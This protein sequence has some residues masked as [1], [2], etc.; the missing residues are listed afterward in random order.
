[1][2]DV[3]GRRDF[4]GFL[5]AS[6]G[7]A[8]VCQAG[9]FTDGEHPAL[10][11][12]ILSDIHLSDEAR[13]KSKACIAIFENTLRFYRDNG[14]DAVIIAG[15]LTNGGWM[16]EMH[17]VVEAWK[18]AFEGG[19]EPVRVIVTGNHERDFFLKAKADGKLDAAACAGALYNDIRANWRQLFGEEWTPFFIRRVKGYAFI[20]AHW[21]ENFDGNALRALLDSHRA[22][23]AG[24]KPFFFV[25]HAHPKDTCYGP[26]AWDQ[27]NGGATSEVLADYPNAVAF[28]GHT[29]YSLVDER[30]VW[31]GAFTSVGTAALRCVYLPDGRENSGAKTRMAWMRGGSQGML[32]E[33]YPRRLRLS[34]YELTKMKK[35]GE[36][37]VVPVPA[38]PAAPAFAFA[39]RASSANAP[40]FPAGAAIDVISRQGKSPNGVDEEQLTVEFT[41]AAGSGDSLSRVFDYEVRIEGESGVTCVKR[42]YQPGVLGPLPDRLEAASCVFGVCEL[43]PSLRRIIVT[44]FNSLGVKGRPLVWSGKV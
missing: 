39:A 6:V 32:M 19:P 12:G 44:P 23:L 14:V 26:T 33:V 43:P 38:S 41:A 34:R 17:V 35:I 13:R 11:V 28:S 8:M 20:G 29:H 15:D 37:W 21:G 18:H 31:Q 24:P 5:S 10:K 25:Q 2:R 42:V 9:A 40:Q 22:E 4:L 27:K 7:G 1:M 16:S 30:S 3:I 36:D